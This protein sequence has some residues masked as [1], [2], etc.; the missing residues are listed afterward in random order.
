MTKTGQ[1]L[2]EIEKEL[3]RAAEILA[4]DDI[5]NFIIPTLKDLHE[6]LKTAFE[7]PKVLLMVLNKKNKKAEKYLI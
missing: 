2:D 4:N 7:K 6:S 5:K 3:E 1:G